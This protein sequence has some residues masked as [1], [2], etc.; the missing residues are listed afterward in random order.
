MAEGIDERRL[1]KLMLIDGNSL[2]NRAF[3]AIRTFTTR[4][5]VFTN[6]VYGFLTILLKILEEEKPDGLC[7]AFDMRAPTFRSGL[8]DKYKAQRAG[9]PDE[10]ASQLP[11]LK[12]VL[13]AMRVARRELEGYEADDILGTLSRQAE[14]AGTSVVV[15][16]GD[17]DSLQLI[18][19]K[20]T[21]KLISTAMGKTGTTEYTPETFFAE[22]GFTPKMMIDYKAL[23]GDPSDNIPGVKGIGKKTA[24]DLI[25]GCGCL[26]DIY[27]GLDALDIKQNVKDKLSADKDM[28][29]LSYNLATIDRNVPLPYDPVDLAVEPYDTVRLYNLFLR[30]EFMSLI[31]KLGLTP[32]KVTAPVEETAADEGY[33]RLSTENWKEYLGEAAG[34]KLWLVCAPE[35]AAIACFDGEKTAVAVRNQF[36]TA[37]YSAFLTGLFSADIKKC[38]ID[39]KH[40]MKQLLDA[41][42]QPLGYT[43][44]CAL[45][46]YLI[47]PLQGSY[48]AEKLSI[49]LLNKETDS[50]KLYTITDAF[51]SFVSCEA[52]EK[53]LCAHA[54]LLYLIEPLLVSALKSLELT[55]LFEQLELPLCRVIAEME[56]AGIL[57]D[58]AGIA[59]F[60]EELSEK[61]GGLQKE[62]YTLAGE[63]FNINSTKSLAALLFE[64][65][66]LPPVKKT[67]TGYSTDIEVLEKLRGKH[68]I[69][70]KIVDYRQLS[71]LKSTYCDGL[72]KFIGEDGRIHTNF[73]MTATATGRL[74][75]TD[76]NLQNIPI[77]REMGSELRRMFIAPEGCV[78]VDADYSQIELRILAHIANDAVMR[79]AFIAGED[80]HARTASQVFGTPL[81][82]VT[83]EQRRRAKAVNFGIVYGISDFSLAEDIGVLRSEAKQYIESYLEH[84]SGVREYMKSIVEKARADGYVTTILN[85]RRNIPEIASKNYNIRSFGERA[86]MNTPIQGSA[87]D[88]IK[89]AM[90]RVNERLKAERLT[91]RLILQIHDELI[92][93][94]PIEEAERVK[95]LLT[96]EMEGVIDLSLPLRAEATSGKTW[97][98]AK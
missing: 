51:D 74:S 88:V 41:D 33:V 27:S 16:T 73:N 62:I 13:D 63:E 23:M 95:A 8:Y 34:K 82:L 66:M 81:E 15:V 70:G 42:I 43:F 28:A 50:V 20:T 69:V 40:C 9:M 85:R 18:S 91:A 68:P 6:A 32:E 77:R 71:K 60:S 5:G 26:S 83:S 96:E 72:T 24:A 36:S 58:R 37:D 31:E 76:P 29:F 1:K 80:I 39:I 92:C 86:A 19:E 4:D 61:I 57:I 46:A 38:G 49:S 78:L 93:E 75:S 89:L 54:R 44:D 35:L 56:H 59:R 97:Y 22:Y 90:L 55:P 98:D 11:I 52:A 79:G 25:K 14:E 30:L 10:L 67:K 45:A 64:K 53:A 94:A 21:V 17:K 7:V 2:I 84:Y 3:Y 48:N 12:E 87:A 65:L 47:D